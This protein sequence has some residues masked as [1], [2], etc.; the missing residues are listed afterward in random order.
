MQHHR[1]IPDMPNSRVVQVSLPGS[2]V[3]VAT[4]IQFNP[5]NGHSSRFYQVLRLLHE[6]AE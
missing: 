3:V 5:K 4:G 1:H 2:L 6:A